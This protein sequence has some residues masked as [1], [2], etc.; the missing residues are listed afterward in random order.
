MKFKLMI[1]KIMTK[2]LEGIISLLNKLKETSDKSAKNNNTQA[3]KVSKFLS[4]II[5]KLEI[6]KEKNIVSFRAGLDTI[7][8]KLV[9]LGV[10]LKKVMLKI[11]GY[12]KVASI[13]IIALLKVL[14]IKIKE[15]IAE[16]KANKAKLGEN[17]NEA[18]KAL[19]TEEL[20][21]SDE[22]KTVEISAE[23]KKTK[24]KVNKT[25][26]EIK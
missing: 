11:W 15:K 6:N 24:K 21:N 26:D 17:A 20:N 8:E 13:K 4:K 16:N 10:F 25:S 1:V 2:I 18:T 12:I 7:S 14:V 9:V 3:Q 23:T 22:I 19:G 5:T